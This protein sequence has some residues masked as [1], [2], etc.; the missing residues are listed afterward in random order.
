MCIASDLYNFFLANIWTFSLVWLA[1]LGECYTGMAVQVCSTKLLSGNGKDAMPATIR[2]LAAAAGSP[3]P[4]S[5]NSMY[6]A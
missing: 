4:T 6:N 5:H 2:R 1:C 3:N